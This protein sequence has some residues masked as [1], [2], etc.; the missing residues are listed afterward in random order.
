MIAVSPSE[1]EIIQ[2]IIKKHTRDCDVLAFGSRLK[3]THNDASDLDLAIKGRDKLPTKT[4][5]SMKDDFML[6][7]IPFKVDV[8][9]YHSVSDAFRGIIDAGNERIFEGD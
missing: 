4:I 7:D 2:G 6:S 5:F 1:M 3:W 9:D 8:L